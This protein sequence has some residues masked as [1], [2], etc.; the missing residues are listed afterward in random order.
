MAGWLAAPCLAETA[1]PAAKPAKQKTAKPAVP[2]PNDLTPVAARHIVQCPPPKAGPCVI[3]KPIATNYR[4]LTT[5]VELED[6]DGRW[7]ADFSKVPK[8]QKLTLHILGMNGDL[9]D[10]EVSFRANPGAPK[11]APQLE[12]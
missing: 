4:L 1:K 3:R 2:P 8:A 12:K 11:I 6:L 7:I 5:G 9:H 10:I